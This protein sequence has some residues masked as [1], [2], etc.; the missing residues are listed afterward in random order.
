M[1]T[2]EGEGGEVRGGGDRGEGSSSAGHELSL[3]ITATNNFP[4]RSTTGDDGVRRE[5]KEMTARLL[6]GG[7]VPRYLFYLGF[8]MDQSVA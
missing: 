4:S 3:V 6:G 1:K 8:I 5:R 2:E 7:E